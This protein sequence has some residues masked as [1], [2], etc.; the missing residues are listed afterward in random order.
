MIS[1]FGIEVPAHVITPDF[2]KNLVH[3]LKSSKGNIP[4]SIYVD[5]PETKY[6]VEFISK[7]FQI[8]VTADFIADVRDLGLRFKVSRKNAS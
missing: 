5:D 6:A 4:V 8:S 7:K 2:R 3:V 1:E